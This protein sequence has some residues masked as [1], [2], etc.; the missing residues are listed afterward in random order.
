MAGLVFILQLT[1]KNKQTKN[2]HSL[3]L[4][5]KALVLVVGTVAQ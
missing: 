3:A 2:I 4:K 1:E 5:L